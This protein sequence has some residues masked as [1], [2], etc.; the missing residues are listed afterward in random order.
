MAQKTLL[1]LTTN[2]PTRAVIKI[3]GKNYELRAPEDFGLKEDAEHKRTMK[4]LADAGPNQ[5]W[6]KMAEAL[7]TMLRAVVIDIPEE[8]VNKLKD[9]QKMAII[10]AFTTETVQRRQAVSPKEAAAV[11]QA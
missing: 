3:D 1:E 4:L 2:E 9:N 8:L 10:Q 11:A 5:D 6:Q 7:N